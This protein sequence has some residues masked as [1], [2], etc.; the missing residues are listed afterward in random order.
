MHIRSPHAANNS[1]KS[2]EN[3]HD[4]EAWLVTTR[5]IEPDEELLWYYDCTQGYRTRS[6]TPVPAEANE[7]KTAPEANVSKKAAAEAETQVDCHCYTKCV[8]VCQNAPLPD[9]LSRNKRQKVRHFDD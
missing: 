1:S 4:L 9:G 2:L 7:A 8:G 6:V 5:I 3:G